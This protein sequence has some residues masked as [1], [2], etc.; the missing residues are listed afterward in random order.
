MVISSSGETSPIHRAAIAV[1]VSFV[2]N[3][4]E[5]LGDDATPAI[6]GIHQF[7]GPSTLSIPYWTEIYHRASKL[8]EAVPEFGNLLE[9]EDSYVGHYW[10]SSTSTA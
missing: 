7:L 5:L 10:R 6:E 9:Q 2:A 3:F 8:L 1:H 4:L